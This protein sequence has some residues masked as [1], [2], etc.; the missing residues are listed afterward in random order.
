MSLIS[1]CRLAFLLFAPIFNAWTTSHRLG[2]TPPRRC[3]F[4]HAHR[5][6]LKH[7]LRCS[8]AWQLVA[9]ARKSVLPLPPWSLCDILSLSPLS[10]CFDYEAL[11][12][13]FVLFFAYHSIKYS[14]PSPAA[15]SN[16]RTLKFEQSHRLL[17][18]YCRAA[19]SKLQLMLGWTNHC[20]VYSTWIYMGLCHL[21]RKE[22]MIWG[23]TLG[24]PLVESMFIWKYQRDL[25]SY[26]T[27]TYEF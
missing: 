12:S 23:D 22:K 25:I 1:F 27:N 3:H 26:L 10:V 15:G 16:A 20:C 8:H 18:G 7:I 14:S 17:F 19:N 9:L 6:C 21:S 5:D 4:C 24:G 11:C 2:E 13:L